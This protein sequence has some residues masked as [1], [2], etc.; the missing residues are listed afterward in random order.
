MHPTPT[1]DALN[2]LSHRVIGLCIE[3]QRELGPG[4]LES[5]YE[6]ALVHE[7]TVAGLRFERQKERPFIYKGI[8]LNCGHRI[9][10]IVENSIILELKSAQTLTRHSQGATAHLPE[11]GKSCPWSA[12]QF[13]RPGSA[14][15]IERVVRGNTFKSN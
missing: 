14:R 2:Q 13:Q 11:T 3:V 5:A 4:L 6:E 15:S 10:L 7:L 1:A 9:D 8:D 12:H